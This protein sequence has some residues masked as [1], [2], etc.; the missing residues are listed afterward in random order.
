MSFYYDSWCKS[1]L[2]FMMRKCQ[3]RC[4]LSMLYIL[5]NFS[6]AIW[7]PH[8]QL[9]VNIK[10]DS[11]IRKNIFHSLLSVPLQNYFLPWGSPWL[12]LKKILFEEKIMLCYRSIEI[13]NFCEIRRFQNLRRHYKHYW[14][15]EVTHA[16]SFESKVLSERNIVKY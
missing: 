8:D 5:I 4:M 14:I 1:G 11:L 6:A 2:F 10:G 16:I 13:F 7:L 9:W 12:K 3:L 15:M